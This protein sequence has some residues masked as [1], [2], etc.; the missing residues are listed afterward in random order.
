MAKKSAKELTE[1]VKDLHDKQL[2][3][4]RSLEDQREQALKEERFDEGANELKN[5]Y[6]SY[7]RAGFT[8]KQAWRIIEIMLINTTKKTLF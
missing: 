2:A 6:D 7:I 8:E 5:A 1:Q 4:M 3:E